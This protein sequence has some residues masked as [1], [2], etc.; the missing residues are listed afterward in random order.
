MFKEFTVS[1][2]ISNPEQVRVQPMD[3]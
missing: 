3:S 1:D 2:T